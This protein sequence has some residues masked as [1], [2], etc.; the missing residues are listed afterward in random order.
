METLLTHLSHPLIHMHTHTHTVDDHYNSNV[1]VRRTARVDANVAIGMQKAEVD[2]FKA[3]EQTRRR[4][5]EEKW[6]Q[7]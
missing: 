3:E 7:G 1:Q 6:V 4:E 2:R 5:L